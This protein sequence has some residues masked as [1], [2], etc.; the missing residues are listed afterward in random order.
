[1][2]TTRHATVTTPL[3]DELFL[4][5]MHGHEEL[6]QPF[7][8]ELNLLSESYDIEASKLLGQH[9]TVHLETVGQQLRHFDGI[10]SQFAYVGARGRYAEYRA[11]L[12]PWLWLLTQS[13]GNAVFL[14]QT[15]P[16]L[17]LQQLRLSGYAEL[18]P[19]SLHGTYDKRELIV[20][21][22]ESLFNFVSRWL[23]HEG[24]YYYFTHEEGSHKLCLADDSPGGQSVPE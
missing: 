12:R 2:P 14:E 21:Y 18:G 6:G 24:I 23:E 10:V 4:R 19:S 11:V 3:A 20:Q 15:I 5:R 13:V 1:M 16:D 22:R 17:V 7:V 8:Y 9:V